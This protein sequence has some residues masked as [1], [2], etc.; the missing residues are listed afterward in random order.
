MGNEIVEKND[1]GHIVKATDEEVQKAIEYG[2]MQSFQ[3]TNA[4]E[5]REPYDWKS[6]NRSNSNNNN[7]YKNNIYNN[8]AKRPDKTYNK[9]NSAPYQYNDN[10]LALTDYFDKMTDKE[11]DELDRINYKYRHSFCGFKNNLETNEQTILRKEI[12]KINSEFGL[13]EGMQKEFDKMKTCL[14]YCQN[15]SSDD[16]NF[17]NQLEFY[18]FLSNNFSYKEKIINIIKKNKSQI[19]ELITN[20]K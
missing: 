10:N 5:K 15:L 16:E 20:I 18:D 2:R 6:N 4:K 8:M 9:I 19:P 7:N 13:N 14:L 12:E 17:I 1:Q 3:P 11:K